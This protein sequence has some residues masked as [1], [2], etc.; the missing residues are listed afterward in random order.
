VAIRRAL[1]QIPEPGFEE[2]ET[3]RFLLD[4]IARMPQACM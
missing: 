4:Q 3:Q 2:V 1:H